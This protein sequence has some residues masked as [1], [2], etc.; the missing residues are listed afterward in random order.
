M[1]TMA[2]ERTDRQYTCR[3]ATLQNGSCS[4]TWSAWI[5]SANEQQLSMPDLPPGAHKTNHDDK[6]HHINIT[7][8]GC[9][10]S[11]SIYTT[12]FIVWQPRRAVDTSTNWR[13]SLFCFCTA[14]MEQAT[15]GAETAAIDGLVS[16]GSENISV[17]FCLRASR[18]RLTLWCA[19]G[20]RVGAQ[21][22]CLS[23]SYSYR[24]GYYSLKLDAMPRKIT[25]T[26]ITMY[27][28]SPYT[29]I[30]LYGFIFC[31]ANA[32]FFEIMSVLQPAN[33]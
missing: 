12:R 8:I 32:M 30:T 16:S 28:Y 18:Y 1:E 5:W 15:D 29:G 7:D 33:R 9:Q 22:K 14:S 6:I 26:G 27:Y 31:V 23:Y 19:L 13:Q 11:R 10:Y 2:S 24:C 20:L 17:S 25:I 4:E 3:S 21:Y